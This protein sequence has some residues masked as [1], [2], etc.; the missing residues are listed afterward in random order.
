MD[1]VQNTSILQSIVAS[2]I[3]MMAFK[4]CGCQKNVPK[5]KKE[6]EKGEN[7][8]FNEVVTDIK[9]SSKKSVSSNFV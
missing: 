2:R 1:W 6:K 3:K 4:H 8:L 9:H 5:K 7:V